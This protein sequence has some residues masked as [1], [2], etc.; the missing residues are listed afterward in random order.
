MGVVDAVAL[1]VA[2]TVRVMADIAGGSF[3][4]N[5]F[6]VQAE[7][8]ISEDTVTVVAAVTQ[9][10]AGG[11]LRGVVEGQVL[12]YQYRFESRAVRALRPGTTG[13]RCGIAVMTI[14][15]ANGA[16][17]AQ[18]RDQAGDI[19]VAPRARERMERRIGQPEL[20]ARVGLF[21]LA[22]RGRRG[23]DRKSVV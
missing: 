18:W 3:F 5:M 14:G 8:L 21:D 1:G 4:D 7:T 9:G 23:S 15:A 2:D 16:D 6:V 13:R 17:R 11:A 22:R 10:I 20:Q 12:P 19:G